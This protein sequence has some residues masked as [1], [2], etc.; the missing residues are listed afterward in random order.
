MR[1][2]F[3]EVEIVISAITAAELAR[4]KKVQ[5][6]FAIRSQSGLRTAVGEEIPAAH[7]PITLHHVP[8]E[9]VSR[10]R[11]LINQLQAFPRE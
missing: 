4:A 2:R 6:A 10:F 9:R 3:G 11:L 7:Q 5:Q 1:Q 8:K